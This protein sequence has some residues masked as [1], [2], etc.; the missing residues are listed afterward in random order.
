MKQL[1]A[2]RLGLTPTTEV[3]VF[4]ATHGWWPWLLLYAVLIGVVAAGG[5]YLL[6]RHR[7]GK[8][9]TVTTPS[10]SDVP[11]ATPPAAAPAAEAPPAEAPPP[12][13]P[14]PDA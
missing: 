5:V 9:T 2:A 12:T 14:D 3:D 8:A 4:L 1:A 11:A 13:T 6:R 10:P 7:S